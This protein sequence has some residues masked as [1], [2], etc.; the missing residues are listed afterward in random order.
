MQQSLFLTE[1]HVGEDGVMIIPKDGNCFFH[2]LIRG[3]T[4]V[5]DQLTRQGLWNPECVTGHEKFRAHV[6]DTMR[7]KIGDDRVLQGH[8]DSAIEAYVAVC[9]A[10]DQEEAATLNL[11]EEEG[12]DVSAARARLRQGQSER[13]RLFDPNPRLRHEAY[14]N[15][16]ATL[17]FFASIAEIYTVSRMFKVGIGIE[18]HFGNRHLRDH[19]TNVNPEG[20]LLKITLI[21]ENGNHFNLKVL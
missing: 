16:I 2:S 4:Q 19:D 9:D 13:K 5:Q 7:R 1:Y 18:R 3:L 6:V 8:V 20:S 14:L 11:L 15:K 12:T 10:K 21:L 17:G